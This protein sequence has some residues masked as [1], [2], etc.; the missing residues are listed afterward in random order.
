VSLREPSLIPNK[1]VDILAKEKVV[2][3][4][5]V[6]F[7][8]NGIM[9]AHTEEELLAKVAQHARTVHHLTEITDE[10]VKKV[11]SVIREE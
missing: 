1:E 11:K 2:R 6:G 3:C 10:V 8:C 9:R 4:R 7:D 5:E